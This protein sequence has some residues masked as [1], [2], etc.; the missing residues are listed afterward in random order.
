MAA[1]SVTHLLA[2]LQNLGKT[3]SSVESQTDPAVK[4]DPPAVASDKL[5]APLAGQGADLNLPA[6]SP[7]EPAGKAKVEPED[8]SVPSP[9]SFTQDGAAAKAASG[10]VASAKL[11][12][13]KL[14]NFGKEVV[15][16]PAAAVKAASDAAES[17][18]PGDALM[19]VAFRLMETSRGQSLV[20]EALEEVE[21]QQRAAELVKAAADEQ[22]N[23]LRHYTV[24]RLKQAE[25]ED[26]QLKQAAAVAQVEAEYR[27]LTKNATAEQLVALEDSAVLLK[28]AEAIFVENPTAHAAYQV[29][30]AAAQKMAAAM[31]GGMPPEQ[32]GAEGAGDSDGPVDPQE[33]MQALQALVEQGVIKPEEAEALAQQLLAGGGGEDPTGGAG[34]PPQG[35]GGMPPGAGGDP[36]AQKAASAD[37]ALS[38]IAEA[39]FS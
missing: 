18:V 32:A 7:T 3:A 2:E 12:K 27:E 20:L 35:A 11:L 13:D 1:K 14:A 30:V 33:I 38:Q 16:A 19:K 5:I 28:Q 6:V 4:G 9:E 23:F 29:G 37:A 36:M 34:G 26:L 8:V 21:G 39:I 25:A 15:P 17:Y 10:I 22:A 24:E 31:E